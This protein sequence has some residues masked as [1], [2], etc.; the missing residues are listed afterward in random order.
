MIGETAIGWGDA[1]DRL[2]KK[3]VHAS[4]DQGINFFDTA[5]IYGL[6]HSEKLLGEWI[7]DRKD[8]II[9]SKVGNV[10]QKEKFTVDYSKKHILSACDASLKRLRRDYIDYYHLHSARLEHLNAEEC[11]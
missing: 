3:A 9:A 2:S 11:V 5:D 7:G 4:L 10:A 6:G 8:I 1:D